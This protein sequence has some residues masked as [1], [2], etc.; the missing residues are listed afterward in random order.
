M[1][2]KNKFLTAAIPP[3]FVKINASSV[4]KIAVMGCSR[5]IRSI[6]VKVKMDANTNVYFVTTSALLQTI[7]M[8]ILQSRCR[9]G[10][11]IKKQKSE[12]S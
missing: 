1:T 2:I 3:M 7:S 8:M 5:T 11:K 12:G 9:S 10:K 6:R 4:I